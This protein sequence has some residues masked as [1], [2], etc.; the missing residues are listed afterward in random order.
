MPPLILDELSERSDRVTTTHGTGTMSPNVLG[1]I[2]A[3]EHSGS[4]C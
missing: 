3:A 4:G 2:E 1:S